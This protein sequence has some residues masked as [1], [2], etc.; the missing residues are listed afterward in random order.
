MRNL[1]SNAEWDGLRLEGTG[2]SITKQGGTGWDRA[3]EDGVWTLIKEQG[4]NGYTAYEPRNRQYTFFFNKKL[5][6]KKRVL[7]W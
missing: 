6:H 7:H 1:T 5:V 3:E 2:R 4:I